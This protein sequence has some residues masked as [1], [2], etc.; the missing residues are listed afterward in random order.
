MTRKLASIK[1][2]SDIQPIPGRDRIVLATVDGWS[3][4]VKRDEFRLGERCVYV[5]IDSILPEK[6]EFEFLRSKKF[7]IKTMKMAGVISQGIVFPLSILPKG[8]YDLDQ[9]VTDIIGIRQYEKTMDLDRG[10]FREKPE[11]KYPAF[12]MKMQW[13]RNLVSAKDPNAFPTFVSKTD[14]IRIQN[15]PSYLRNK[16]QWVATEKIDGQSGTFFVKKEKGK[17]FWNHE[18]YD[19]GVCS[20]NLRL[21]EKDSSSYWVVAEKYKIQDVLMRNIGTDE[22]LALQGE[23]IA[24]NVQGNKYHVTEPDL[25]IFNVITPK[26]RLGSEK[27]AEWCAANGLKFVPIL[28]RSVILPDT[29]PEVLEY[30]HG[31]SAIGDTLREGIVFRSKDGKQ[32]FKAVDPLFLLEYDE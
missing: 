2:I 18:W 9:D 4:I 1:I 23:C 28:D 3:V 30:A 6:A 31:K 16:E 5:E 7:R 17:H 32:S 11:K 14:E 20:R 22:F 26:G 12:L 24:P 27:A 10:I 13:F 21:R 19:F 25:Y 8:N 29:V 15:A